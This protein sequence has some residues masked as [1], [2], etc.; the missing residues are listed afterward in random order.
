VKFEG[1]QITNIKKTKKSPFEYF[2]FF[3]FFSEMDAKFVEGGNKSSHSNCI[4]VVVLFWCCCGGL[5]LKLAGL[6]QLPLLLD[7][8]GD[9]DDPVAGGLRLAQLEP[10]K[11]SET[12]PLGLHL[13]PLGP[14]RSSPLL[15]H[16]VGDQLL[17]DNPGGSVEGEV[18]LDGGQVDLLHGV[19]LTTH[20]GSGTVHEN[21]ILV[22]HVDNGGN[23]EY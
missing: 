8:E 18:D 22:D 7:V 16:L 1:R 17:A 9:S 12:G 23:L 10:V 15:I 13:K 20:T 21:P 19:G 2:F 11:V 4:V 6:S 3:F 5:F 14:D